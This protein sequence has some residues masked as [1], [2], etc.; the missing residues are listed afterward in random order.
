MEEYETVCMSRK[1]S[2]EKS[3][4]YRC[5]RRHCHCYF[6]PSSIKATA[7][8]M[9]ENRQFSF[10]HPPLMAYFCAADIHTG[11]DDEIYVR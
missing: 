8:A 6:V 2:D 3:H 5:D 10:I 11:E 7:Q 4:R 1:D 9:K